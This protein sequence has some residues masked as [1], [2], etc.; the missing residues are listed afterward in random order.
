MVC[1]RTKSVEETVEAGRKLGRIL[2]GGDVVC[3]SGDL[4]AGKTAFTGGIADALGIKGYVTSPTFTIVNE[5]DS[6]RIPLYHFD[7]YRL[8]DP[9]ELIE[10]G[11]EEYLDSDGVVVIEWADLVEKVLP[12][13][14]IKVEI[15]RDNGY[16]ADD[17]EIIIQFVGKRYMEYEGKMA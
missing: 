7:V 3:L 17:R 14:C 2:S 4:G 1:I 9:D 5:Y 11:I 10:I 6:G 16:S 15:K 8:G 13:E 12:D